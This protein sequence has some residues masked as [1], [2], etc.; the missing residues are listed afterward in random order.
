MDVPKEKLHCFINI[1]DRFYFSLETLKKHMQKSHRREYDLLKEEYDNKNFNQIYMIVKNQR[2]FKD[3]MSFINFK[4]LASDWDQFDK[5][6]K[7]RTEN[8]EK[9]YSIDQNEESNFKD[10]EDDESNEINNS[11]DNNFQNG[12]IYKKEKADNLQINEHS[13]KT[14]SKKQNQKSNKINLILLKIFKIQMMNFHLLIRQQTK[15][16]R[17]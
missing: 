12:K 6:I 11:V 5:K 9:N 1:C 7:Y 13:E 14:L 2:E 3:N 10:N 16:H 4:D 15:H 17:E 8:N